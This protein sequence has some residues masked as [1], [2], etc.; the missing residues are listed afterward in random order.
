MIAVLLVASRARREPTVANSGQ[1]VEKMNFLKKVYDR[2][3]L[4]Y[5]FRSHSFE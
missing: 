4:I 3:K 2:K 1:G 5:F